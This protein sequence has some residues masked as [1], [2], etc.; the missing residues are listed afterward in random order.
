MATVS[1]PL[2]GGHVIFPLLAPAGI[3]NLALAVWLLA[4]GFADK[5][6]ATK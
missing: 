2:L 1:L 4:K 3:A 5:S 6:P